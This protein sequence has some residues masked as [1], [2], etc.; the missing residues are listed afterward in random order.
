[1]HVYSRSVF[2]SNSMVI[3]AV[4]AVIVLSTLIWILFSPRFGLKLVEESF[5]RPAS[6]NDITTMKRLVENGLDVNV[7]D[8]N[9]DTPLYYAL[10]HGN[11][12]IADFLLSKGARIDMLDRDGQTLASKVRDVG[13]ARGIGW[14]RKHGN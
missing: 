3:K 5:H 2:R 11:V 13:N 7:R 9:G 12:S 14:L 10:S 6:A 4:A 1:M 8:Q